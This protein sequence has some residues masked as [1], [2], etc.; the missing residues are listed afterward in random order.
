MS[1]D[2]NGMLQNHMYKSLSKSIDHEEA[3]RKAERDKAGVKRGNIGISEENLA[4]LTMKHDEE[5][6]A[7]RRQSDAWHRRMKAAKAGY[8]LHGREEVADAE[9]QREHSE[10]E[11][12]A[13]KS[14]RQVDSWDEPD[15]EEGAS[16]EGDGS[17]E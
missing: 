12:L 3:A 6:G 14:G 17:Q 15:E 9:Y 11:K 4:R 1:L 2:I 16:E 8:L 10:L 5:I 7:H 13:R